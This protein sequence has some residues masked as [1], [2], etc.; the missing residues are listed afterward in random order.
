MLGDPITDLTISMEINYFQLNRAEY[1][2]PIVVKIP[3]RELA[4]AKKMG[5]ERTQID[6]VCEIKDDFGGTTVS[7]IRDSMPPIKLSDKTV[8]Q[9]ARQPIEYGAGVTLLPGHYTI[10]FLARDDET[11]RIGT[12]TATC[13]IPSGLL[14]SMRAGKSFDC[15]S[16]F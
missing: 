13:D 14:P 11:G 1:C 6:F 3:G 5:S 12:L 2:V 15:T 10:K 7:N 16:R 4:I 8:A 9:L